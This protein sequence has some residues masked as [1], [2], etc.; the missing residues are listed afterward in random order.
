ML[1]VLA[2]FSMP[3]M[4]YSFG[5]SP[6]E[7]SPFQAVTPVPICVALLVLRVPLSIHCQSVFWGG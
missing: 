2:V 3:S 1:T 7:V 6:G 4:S 5:L